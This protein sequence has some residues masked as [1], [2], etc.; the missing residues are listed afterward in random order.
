MPALASAFLQVSRGTISRGKSKKEIVKLLLKYERH[1]LVFQGK[2]SRVKSK[3]GAVKLVL[4]SMRGTTSCSKGEI[5]E[6]RVRET[7]M[8]LG[9]ERHPS[10]NNS[11]GY[12]QVERV[13]RG[14]VKLV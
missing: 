6:V 14:I 13:K 1:H 9:Y 11:K 7:S 10:S 5:Q 8:S 4:K 2:N 12:I 3:R